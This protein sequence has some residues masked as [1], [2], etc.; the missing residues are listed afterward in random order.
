MALAKQN[1]TQRRLEV[2][3]RCLKCLTPNGGHPEAPGVGPWTCKSCSEATGAHPESL[4]EDKIVGCPLCGCPDIY[5]QR[6][7]NRVLGV[8]II[9]VGAVLA[10]FTYYISL[11]VFAAVDFLV[12]YLVRDVVCCHHCQAQMRGYPGTKEAPDFDL[13]VSDKYLEIERERGW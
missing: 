10:P 6:D 8:A 3:W 1:P 11:A 13:N 9:V 2:Q 7:F 12:F 5:R 4:R